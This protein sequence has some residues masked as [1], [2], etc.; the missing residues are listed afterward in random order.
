MEDE[1]FLSTIEE[2]R[3]VSDPYRYRILNCFYKLQQP[4]TVKQIADEMG[5]VPANV[6]YHVKKMEKV[7]ILK[8]VHTK[9]INGIIAKYYEPTAR[10]FKIVGQDGKEENP[11]WLSETHKAISQIYDESKR[12]F[13]EHAKREWE[14]KTMEKGTVTMEQLYLTPGEA[15]EL[16]KYVSDFIDKNCVQAK[17]KR[18]DTHEYHCLFSII[19]VDAKK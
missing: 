12:V 6:H 5:E 2:I 14:K 3:G 11:E 8:L 17:E 10:K 9:E 16:M 18:E 15:Q 4:A 7:G 1:K 13:L 19:A